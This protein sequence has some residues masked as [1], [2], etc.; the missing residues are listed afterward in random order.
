MRQIAT[1]QQRGTTVVLLVHLQYRFFHRL[2]DVGQERLSHNL[3]Q[4]L[5]ECSRDDVPV[6]A[7]AIR[8]SGDIRYEFQRE[9]Q[10]VPRHRIVRHDG[11]D[12][13]AGGALGFE[14]E[15][16]GAGSIL[17][18]GIYA[19]DCVFATA[20]SG[21]SYGYPLHTSEAF[22][23]DQRSDLIDSHCVDWFRQ[24]GTYHADYVSPHAISR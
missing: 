20:K 4:L 11:R 12:G 2:S 16:L 8:K 9:L 23:A 19:S 5:Q 1:P 14:L 10:C 22:L 7:L 15:R 6:I 18:G 13:F 17:L 21:H 24:N 3:R